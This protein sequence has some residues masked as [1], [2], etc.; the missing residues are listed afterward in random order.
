MTS[1]QAFHKIIKKYDCNTDIIIN[2]PLYTSIF[3]CIEG[4]AALVRDIHSNSI[5]KL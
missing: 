1:S 2:H 3:L 4:I 5:G